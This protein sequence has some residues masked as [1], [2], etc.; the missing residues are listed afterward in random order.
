RQ[1]TEVALETGSRLIYDYFRFKPGMEKQMSLLAAKY[2]GCIS[3]PPSW[4]NLV[5]DKI[6]KICNELG[7]VCEP[8]FPGRKTTPI[9]LTDFY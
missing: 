2:P 8:A 9:R 3:A 5:R 7:V 1:I 4:R 6:E